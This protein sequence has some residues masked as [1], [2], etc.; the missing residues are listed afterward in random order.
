MSAD[1][2]GYPTEASMDTA[3]VRDRLTGPVPSIRVPFAKSGAI[4]YEGLANVVE[5]NVEA[6]GRTMLLTAGDSHLR[7]MSP[8]EVRSV[9]EATVEATDGRA[10]VVAA[11][12]EYDTGRAVEFAR[13]ATDAGAD[14]VMCLP[15]D[16]A[17]SCT[18]ESLA[19]HYAAV[20][21]HAPVMVVT[22]V[23]DSHCDDFGLEA[24]RATLDRTDDIVA[25]KDDLGGAFARRLCLEF[26]DECAVIAGGQK[27]NHM[28]M[29]PY[30]CDGY[31]STFLTFAPAVSHRYW[32]A[33]EADDMMAARE[34]IREYDLPLF[35]VLTSLPG[36]FDAGL[37]GIMELCGI[38]GRHRRPP[39]HTLNDGELDPLAT[40]LDER[41]LR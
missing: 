28:N 32:S 26:H 7:C 21:E 41:G 19:R 13:W 14:V 17:N 9:T 5:F 29:L 36:G 33:I 18:P 35:D 12:C 30:G 22:N 1:R 3:Q 24:I 38:A 37:H 31:L 10:M 40:F 25:I 11:D 16:W 34:V 2:D 15:P 27:Q 4:D 6:G 8:A 39:H 23:F 20:A